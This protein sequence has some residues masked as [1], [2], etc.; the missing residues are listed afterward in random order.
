ML[1]I[2]LTG[3]IG[4]GKST[5]AKIFEILGI[6]VYYADDA[7]KRLM[8]TD[9]ELKKEIIRHFGDRAYAGGQLDRSYIAQRVFDNKENLQLLNSLVHPVT[10]HDAE[11]WMLQQTAPYAIKEAALIFETGLHEYLDYTIGVSAPQ[12]LRISRTMKRAEVSQ[13]EVLN[14]MKNQME[15]ETK[16]GLCDF[17]IYND[18]QQP[19]LSQ[20]LQTHQ[21]LL[22]ISDK[23]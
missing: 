11:K 9:A 8:N 18:E 19:V 23:K 17:V 6:P 14:R 15:E 2:G 16:M 5:V 22:A 10:K 12:A 4:S 13:E 3:G 7:A 1:K 21:K 20:V